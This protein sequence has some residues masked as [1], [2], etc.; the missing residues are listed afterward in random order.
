MPDTSSSPPHLRPALEA[1]LT[2]LGNTGVPGAVIGGLAVG[3]HAQ[4]RTTQDVD[5]LTLFDLAGLDRFLKAAAEHG[6]EFRRPD[7]PAVARENRVVLLRHVPS[8][9]SVDIALGCMPFDREAVNNA[10]RHE[11]AGVSAPTATSDDLI[12]MKAVA[13]RPIDTGDIDML[14]S[15]RPPADLRR[16]RRWVK[17]YAELLHDDEIVAV[18]EKV[19]KRHVGT[20]RNKPKGV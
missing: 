3:V 10:V 17:Q 9:V 2:L 4:P 1:L 15:M 6:F 20:K 11:I 19:L 18:L 12:I 7:V 13:H 5:V 14:L 8:G 16:I